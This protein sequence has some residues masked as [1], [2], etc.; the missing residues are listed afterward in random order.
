MEQ[1]VID[2]IDTAEKNQDEELMG[3][4]CLLISTLAQTINC[5]SN[6]R[7]IGETLEETYGEDSWTYEQL[8][9]WDHK[10]N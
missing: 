8:K 9:L 7:S 5:P 2:M 4:I 6:W 3:Y 10:S 1:L